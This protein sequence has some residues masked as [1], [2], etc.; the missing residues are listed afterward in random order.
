MTDTTLEKKWKE[1]KDV[2][3]DTDEDGEMVLSE[4][5]WVFEK[6]TSRFDIWSYFDEKY[7]KGV[8][9]LLYGD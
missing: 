9:F 4:D 1:L 3:F 2:P 6:G 7:S 8:H 5:W